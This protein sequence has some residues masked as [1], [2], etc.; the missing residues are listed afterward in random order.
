MSWRLRVVIS[1]AI[2]MALPV[3][4]LAQA[5]DTY[6]EEYDLYEKAQAETNLTQRAALLIEFVQKYKESQLDPNVAYL[7]SQYLDGM[8]QKGQWAQVAAASEKFLTYRPSDKVVVAAATEA[9]Q[10]LGQPGKLVEFG[11]KVYNQAPNAAS[12]YLVAKAYK[13]MGDTANF[14]KWAQRTLKHAPNNAEMLVE[15]VNSAWALQDMEKA[16]A[17]AQK[18][19]AALKKSEDPQLNPSKA[20]A[21]RAIGEQAYI[22]GDF[23]TAQGNFEQAVRL[24]P[25]VDFGHLRLGYCYWRASKTDQAILSFARAVALQGSSSKEARRELYNLLRQRQGSTANA[26]KIIQAAKQELGIAN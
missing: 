16:S 13:S 15:L 5:A 26:T 12:A 4:I 7:Y 11:T 19:L 1:V 8:R 24:D 20:F 14:E 21:Y 9:Y 17:Y 25:M 2:A 6:A 18:A 3:G 22:L 23:N 10:Q